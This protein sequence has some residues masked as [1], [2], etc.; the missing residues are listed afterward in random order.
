[1]SLDE[2]LQI[3]VDLVQRYIVIIAILG[4]LS[5]VLIAIRFINEFARFIG[6]ITKFF[7]L[8]FLGIY[9]FF[10]YI[11]LFLKFIFIDIYRFI[12][13]WICQFY[14]DANISLSPKALNI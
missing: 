8:I 3:L 10:K 11:L 14:Q 9:Y 2:F 6:Y 4:A 13:R 12:N 7:K 5:L 1:M